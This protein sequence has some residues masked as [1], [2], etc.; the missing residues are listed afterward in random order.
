MRYPR[1]ETLSF[2]LDG[3]AVKTPSFMQKIVSIAVLLAGFA[4]FAAAP[5]LH[6]ASSESKNTR[7][8]FRF[9]A[10]HDRTVIFTAEGDLWRGSIAG[11]VA[12]RLTS[13]P[14]DETHAAISSDGK[15]VAFSAE[16]EGP[17]EVYTMPIEGGVPV[18]RTFEGASAVVV[19]W[20][21]DGQVLYATTKY[22]TLPNTQLAT[23]DFN[24]ATRT[25]LPLAQASQGVF[26]DDHKQFFFTRL[27]FQGSSTKRYKGG[28]VQNLWKFVDGAE[29]AVPLIPDY[30]GTSKNAMWWNGRIFYLCDEDGIMNLWSMNTEGSDR[31][32][33]TH[34]RSWD[35]KNASLSDGR[36]VYSIGADLHLYEIASGED[37]LLH[38]TLQSDYDQEREKWIKKPIEYLTSAHL[39][40][41][42][43]RVVLTARGQ[44]FVAPAKDG[45]FVDVTHNPSVRFRNARFLSKDSM[46]TLSDQSGELEFWKLPANGLGAPDQITKN[47]KVLRFDGVPSP[48]EKW[49]AYIDKDYRLFILNL[50]DNTEIL[51]STSNFSEQEDL[52]WSPDGQWLAYVDTADNMYR[53]IFLYRPSDQT[54]IE[55]TGNRVESYS[56][57]WSPDGKWIYFLSDRELRSAVKSPWG[58]LQP[59]P[60]F[61]EITRVY[62]VALKKDLR[63]PFQAADELHESTKEDKNKDKEK[64]DKASGETKS[65]SAKKDEKDKPIEVTIDQEG[66]AQRLYQVPVPA[67]NYRGL[68]VTPKHLLWVKHETSFEA[69]PA[70]QQLE[71]SS[72]SPKP[73]TIIEDIKSYELSADGKKMLIYKGDS[74]YV[75]DADADKLDEKKKV[76]LGAWQF[77]INPRDE[78]RQMF[79]ESWRLM[80]DY[81]YDRNMHGVPWRETLEK[82]LPLVDRVTD[83][84]ELN[85]LMADL[86]GELSALHTFIRGGDQREGPDNIAVASLGAEMHRDAEAGG[87]RIERIYKA[88]PDYPDSLSPLR[89]P[90]VDVNEGDVLLSINGISLLSVPEPETLLRSKAGE[91]VLLE[92]Q[93]PG[94]KE[95]RKVIVEPVSPGAASNLRYADW[96]FSRRLAV[97]RQSDE[98]IGYVH[99]RAMG[100]ANIAEWAREYYPIFQRQGLIID[101]RHNR[102]G[103]IDSWILE[104]LLRKPWF[105]WQGR[106]GK[107]TWNMQYAFRGHIVVL[108][109]EFTAS[110]GEA[111]T[112]GF[113][114]LG[115]GK[116]IGTRTWGGEIWLSFS[117]YLVD[118]GIASAA[119]TGVYGPKGSWLIE[120]HGVDPDIIVDNLPHATFKG[121]DAQL[122]AAIK[123]LL[124]EIEK[125]PRPVPAAP[126]YP[127]KAFKA[128][129]EE[130]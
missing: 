31:K 17:Q 126:P 104:K 87:W 109:D 62:Q 59:E 71:I 47:G 29:E 100:A 110:D 68:S 113:K 63:S 118:K 97:E 121:K 7:G 5:V 129:S 107:P 2:F 26:S 57:A 117:N 56:P 92:V 119:E 32:Q 61:D 70:L 19:G 43:D 13:H 1:A 16:Y 128:A 6:G 46:I 116:V 83:R 89:R 60:F 58:S 24:T 28:T 111:F 82:Y 88:D 79:T 102:G 40:T 127:N 37:T 74:L 36:I 115:L 10:L 85:D 65:D 52:A 67:G 34:H 81:F 51:V 11:G 23:F 101:V 98:K 8:Y 76:N 3:F 14:A 21:P 84:A 123:Y 75:L 33:L 45:R 53:Q 30:T 44:V 90:G 106:A 105:Y 66:L 108:C 69:K 55:L 86:M 12:Q 122:D 103:N 54:K 42:G 96:E 72:D 50:A 93:A 48:N 91:Q 64:S 35:I 25:L 95:K 94:K 4:A 114:R 130:K 112:E 41:N 73:K 18:R 78:W 15:T 99:L 22:S 38:F 125:D 80:R 124:D 49:L 9:P 27:P 120:G 20:T 77:S 39:S